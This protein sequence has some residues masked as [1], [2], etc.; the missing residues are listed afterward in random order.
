MINGRQPKQDARQDNQKQQPEQSLVTRAIDKFVRDVQEARSN[1]LH[2]T[3]RLSI[4]FRAGE[5][6]TVEFDT[7]ESMK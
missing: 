5:P 3:L 1:Q 4:G 2:A 7:R 6:V